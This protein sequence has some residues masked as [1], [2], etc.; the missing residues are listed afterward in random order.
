MSIVVFKQQIQTVQS[1]TDLVDISLLL[2]VFCFQFMF[3]SL[4]FLIL[5]LLKESV[6]GMQKMKSVNQV[7]VL[8]LFL[9][10]F[11]HKCPLE[12]IVF[13]SSPTLTSRIDWAF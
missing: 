1:F 5:F 9:H 6:G 11:S 7:Q 2:S 12:R 8:A 13:K 10:F 4:F 3:K